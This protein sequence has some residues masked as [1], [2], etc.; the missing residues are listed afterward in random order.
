MRTPRLA[1]LLVGTTALAGLATNAAPASA[2][3]STGCEGGGFAVTLPSGR[4]VKGD[5]DV[6]VDSRDL[7]SASLLRFRGRYVEFDVAPTTGAI[8][9][10][11]YTG[12]ANPVSMTSTRTTV[13][14]SKT[15]DRGPGTKGRSEISLTG[16]S[17]RVLVSGNIKVKVQAKDCATGGVFQQEVET[18]NGSPVVATHVLAPGAYFYVNP[19]T[20]K[21]NVGNGAGFVAKDSPQV[22][23]RLSQTDSTSVWE[24]S[25][26]AA[27]AS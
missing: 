2:A 8:T 9:H 27:W 24:I 13:W 11:V 26:G 10:W 20:S 12:A 19:Y 4:T 3:T 16:D 6:R 17:L 5:Q 25:S 7:T 14:A 15:L 1:A 18:D 23:K 21:L 22:A